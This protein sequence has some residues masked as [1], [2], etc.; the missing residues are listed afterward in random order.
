MISSF[1]I[2]LMMG[3]GSGAW[4]Y[5][6]LLRTS[7]NNKKNSVIGA[8]ISGALIALIFDLIFNSVFKK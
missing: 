4:I 1:I 5:N 7:G 2:S 6:R 3:L 8:L